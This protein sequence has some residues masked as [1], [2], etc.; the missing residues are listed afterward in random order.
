MARLIVLETVGNYP[1]G[2]GLH[3]GDGVVLGDAISEYTRELD[4][5]LPTSPKRLPQAYYS[6]MHDGPA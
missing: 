1:Q 5:T 6:P 3:P 4:D 2:K